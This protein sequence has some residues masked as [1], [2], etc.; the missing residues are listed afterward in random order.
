MAAMLRGDICRLSESRSR[1]MDKF[2]ASSATRE[3]KD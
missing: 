2:K 1:Y 3:S